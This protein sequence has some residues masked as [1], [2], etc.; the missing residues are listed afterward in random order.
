ML[1]WCL[2]EDVSEACVDVFWDLNTG[3]ERFVGGVKR[4]RNIFFFFFNDSTS[5]TG[6]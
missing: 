1:S 6:Y 2:S 4:T 5:S 3:G